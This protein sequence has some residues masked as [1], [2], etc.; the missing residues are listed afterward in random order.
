MDF[1][2]D[3]TTTMI[4]DAVRSFVDGR[5]RDAAMHWNEEGL[6]PLAELAQLGE[7]G[8]LGI[9]VPEAKG[10]AGLNATTLVIALEELAAGDA[11][12][13]LMVATHNAGALALLQ[14]AGAD[15]TLIGPLA[16][17]ERF[18]CVAAGDDPAQLDA[19]GPITMAR[20]TDNGDWRLHGH[21]PLVLLGGAAGLAVVTATV[22]GHE[23]PQGFA[24]DLDGPGVE[25]IALGTRMG[26][27]T[28]DAAGLRFTDAAVGADRHLGSVA[29]AAAI[30]MTWQRLAGAAVAL[31]IG[32]CA[33]QGGVRYTMERSQFGK[34]IARY[35]PIQWQTADAGVDLET[36]RLLTLRAAWLADQG[37]DFGRAAAMAALRASVAC[38]FITD[39]A[40]QMH[41]GYGYTVDF[42]A[43][44]CYRDAHSLRLIC[45]SVER[46]RIVV[47]TAA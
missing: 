25:R 27:R 8:L 16:R 33:L 13:A 3:E 17:G 45:G 32:R 23:G 35:Q 10:G 40:L 46:N 39:R 42:A 4:R 14:A 31:G 9:A 15:D 30:A 44:R 2:L 11:G 19:T 22:D 28:C 21:K 5:V 12:L 1:K 41:G 26:L 47:A 38:E 20:Q 6:V 29:E 34:K 7:L 37:K 18:A 36:T 43:E 24:V